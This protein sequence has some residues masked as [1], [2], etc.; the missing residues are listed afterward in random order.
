[1]HGRLG[2]RC[3]RAARPPAPVS[4]G[5]QLGLRG[6]DVQPR[7]HGIL[8]RGRGGHLRHPRCK[9]RLWRCRTAFGSDGAC[10]EARVMTRLH[11]ALR[12][13]CLH[14]KKRFMRPYA[15]RIV[16]DS[17]PKKLKRKNLYVVEDDGFEEQ[18]ALVCPCGCRAVLHL[19]LHTDERP[20]WR[21][22]R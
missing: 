14:L 8:L 1:Q 4:R 19:N 12:L 18:A 20:C 15:T 3:N 11:E 2:P 16:K 5:A 17:L 10:K 9:G 6:G 13:A 22:T 21:V 7:E